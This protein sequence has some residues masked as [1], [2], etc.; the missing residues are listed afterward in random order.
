MILA[1]DVG[2]TKSNLGAFE[3]AGGKLVCKVWESLPSQKY[4]TFELLVADFLKRAKVKVDAVC[5]GIAGPI[6]DGTVRAT[7]LP[8]MISSYDLAR[9]IGV[10][11]V[12]LL[13]DLEAT[14]YSVLVLEPNE[15]ERI[16]PGVPGEKAT[17]VVIAAGT[18]LGEG[19]LFWDGDKYHPSATEGGHSDWAPNTEQQLD[20]WRYLRARND[21]VSCEII[22]SGRGFP[23]LHAF[24]DP[25][26]KHPEFDATDADPAPLIT[27]HALAGTCPV[28]MRTLD[29]WVEIYGSEAGNLAIRNVARGGIYV[30][31][32]I[33][34]KILP[35][36][37]EGKFAAAAAHKEK[38]ESLLSA[39]PIYVVLNEKAPLIGAAN[40]A[41]GRV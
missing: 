38:M 39:I 36:L 14:C 19:I 28:C 7:N 27:Q 17:K 20:L 16:H 18:G 2:G 3:D 33:A 13:N 8:W 25:S 32:G 35:K 12:R 5:F 24:L 4:P 22:L 29:L 15:L 11:T 37:K 23:E 41:A 10:R 26:V 1:G 30:A 40:V 9:E 34:L 31:G 6:V 21:I